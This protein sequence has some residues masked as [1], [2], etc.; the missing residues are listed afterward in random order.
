[1]IWVSANIPNADQSAATTELLAKGIAK[2]RMLYTTSDSEA[3]GL[4]MGV[5]TALA[6]TNILEIV[7]TTRGPGE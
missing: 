3:D 2:G 6:E 7:D 1:M 4:C 5:V